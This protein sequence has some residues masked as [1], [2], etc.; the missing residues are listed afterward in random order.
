MVFNLILVFPFDYVG[1]AM[2]TSMSATLNAALLYW[3]LQKQGV[4]QLSRASLV[5]IFRTLL[6]ALCMA[7]F[8]HWYAPQDWT[9]F[10]EL[11]RVFE[12]TKQIFTAAL[13]FIL[14]GLIFGIRLNDFRHKKAS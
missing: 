6:A 4:F 7:S 1:L 9:L 10:T 3:A 8:S 12:L 13:V 2:A 14:S 5:F 11:E